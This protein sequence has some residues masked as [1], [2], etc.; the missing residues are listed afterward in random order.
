MTTDPLGEFKS[1]QRETWTLGNFREVAVFT[2]QVAGQLVRFAGLRAGARV[3]DVATGTGVVA[4]TA[5]RL[6]ATVAGLDLTPAL[7]D[8]ARAEAAV[9]GLSEIDW[10][11]GDAESLPY[12]DASFDFV[13]SQFGHIFAP[14]PDVALREML[15]VLRPGGRIAFA[16]WPPEQLIG[17]AHALGERYLPPTGDVPS[18]LLW[19]EPSVVRERL[20]PAVRELFFERGMMAIPALSPQHLFAWQSMNIGRFIKLLGAL[21]KDPTKL[22]LFTRES[23]DLIGSYMF[24]NV[25]RHECLLSRA[26]KV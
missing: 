11:E 24:D 16:S 6:G 18:P 25:V 22:S 19:G 17:R 26:T 3:L 15:R 8:Q 1:K 7:L 13:L 14:R 21:R 20:G 5:A 2:A 4:I 23:I 9:A 12:P 10:K